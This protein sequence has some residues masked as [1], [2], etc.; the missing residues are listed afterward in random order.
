MKTIKDYV[1]KEF[2]EFAKLYE[3][4]PIIDDIIEMKKQIEIWY[5]K[6]EQSIKDYYWTR[7]KEDKLSL[8]YTY[9]SF[10]LRITFLDNGEFQIILDHSYTHTNKVLDK[11]I[12]NQYFA[13]PGYVYFMESKFGW[14][15]GKTRD[16]DKRRK[17]F[18]VK[19]PFK[20]AIRYVVKTHEMSKLEI[21]FHDLFK[22]KHINGEWYLITSDD[23]IECLKN[24]PELRLKHYNNDKKIVIEQW[25][26]V[27]I[28]NGFAVKDINNL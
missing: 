25:Y 24:Y 13:D 28:K 6:K 15:I 2:E 9:K 19:L 22:N 21:L 7:N 20:F 4:A 14:K 23:I 12:K 11:D 27:D 8:F 18:E 26:L 10:K 1:N 5:L 17:T 16:L 3:N